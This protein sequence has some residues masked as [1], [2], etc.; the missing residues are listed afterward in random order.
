MI[1]D[2]AEVRA[3]EQ[4]QADL[5]WL[6]K[7]VEAVGSLDR[8]KVKHPKGYQK[9]ADKIYS[10]LNLY[11]E[12]CLAGYKVD[13]LISQEA[14]AYVWANRAHEISVITKKEFSSDRVREV[15]ESFLEEL[16]ET[17]KG[18]V[19]LSFEDTGEIA[20]PVKEGIA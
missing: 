8:L 14:I 9:I 13:T 6:K 18:L 3:K 5:D 20:K 12:K 1:G 19:Y 7:N 4:L 15:Y 16:T 10:D 11:H 17:Y 2:V